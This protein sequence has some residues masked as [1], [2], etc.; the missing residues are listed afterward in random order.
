D[1][2]NDGARRTLKVTAGPF[3][4]KA[5]DHGSNQVTLVRN[6]RWWGRPAKLSE[7]DLMAV[8]LDKRA[9]ALADGKIDLAEIDPS[10]VQRIDLAGRA[11]GTGTPLMGP[12][13]GRTAARKQ[14]AEDDKQQDALR[15]FEV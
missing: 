5:V 7:I 1:S 12:G 11:K 9:A 4:L 6:P 8:P 2:F 15:G 14:N 13:G 10:A 3:A